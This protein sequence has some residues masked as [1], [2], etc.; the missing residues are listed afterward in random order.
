MAK[1][2]Y[3]DPVKTVSGKLAKKSTITFMVRKA[4]TSNEDMLNNPNYTHIMGKRTTPLNQAEK[5]YR[6]RFGTICAATGR[7][8]QDTSKMEADS[9]AFKAQSQ[10]KTLRQYVWHQVADTIS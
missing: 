1:V 3:I 5:D 6:A 2:T 7:R 9:A 8:L 10:Y 4:A